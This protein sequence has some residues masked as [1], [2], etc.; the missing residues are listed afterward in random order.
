MKESLQDWELLEKIGRT[1]LE[2]NALIQRVGD[3]IGFQDDLQR[4]A[5]DVKETVE[6]LTKA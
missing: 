6:I 5:Q 4:Y 3:K 2:V 1:A